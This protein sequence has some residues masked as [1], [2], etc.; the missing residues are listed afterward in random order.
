MDD[1]PGFSFVQVITTTE[2]EE[3]ARRIAEYLVRER[4]VACAQVSGPLT[5]YYWWRGKLEV[6]REWQCKAKTVRGLA[7]R[8]IV[9]VKAM[10]PYELPQVLCLPMVDVLE[11]Y[12]Q[13][14]HDSTA[15]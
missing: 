3:D 9:A 1:G 14:I 13:W 2:T 10:H 8:V 5:S 4:M 15:T 12:G 7:R 6:S 11:E